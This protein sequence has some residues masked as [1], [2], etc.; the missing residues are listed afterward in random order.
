[1]KKRLLKIVLWVGSIIIFLVLIGIVVNKWGMNKCQSVQITIEAPSDCT[2]LTEEDVRSYIGQSGDS[3]TGSDLSEINIE[4]LE[5]IINQKPYVLNSKVYMSING[6]L[7]IDIT[8]RTPIARIQP[9]TRLV[10]IQNYAPYYISDDGRMMPLTVGKSSRVIFVN[11]NVRNFYCDFLK[12]DVDS[13]RM[14]EDTIGFM[15]TLYTIYHVAKFIN[16][17][18]FFKAQIQ[19]IYVEEN[20]DLVLIP[21]VGN[22]IVIFGD[23]NNISEK[24]R[25]LELFYEKATFI[26]GW[27]KYDTINIKYKNQIICS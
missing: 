25:R 4:K 20:G 19:Q 5:S 13:A 15:K 3:L 14:A 16:Q 24:F 17:N 18:K 2:F 11:G 23:G 22:H 6:I 9:D 1:M 7:K 10:G 8:Q 26:E 21:E 12:L 27:D